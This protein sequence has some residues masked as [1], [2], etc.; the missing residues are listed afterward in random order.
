MTEKT[1]RQLAHGSEVLVIGVRIDETHIQNFPQ[2]QPGRVL[3][4]HEDCLDVQLSD[5]SFVVDIPFDQVEITAD[6][7][8]RS[9][10]SAR[11]LDLVR[12]QQH[13]AVRHER[14]QPE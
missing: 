12:L 8:L 7:R 2:P 1:V 6:H 5:G 13:V 9:E 3:L 10:R 4:V 14:T 11:L